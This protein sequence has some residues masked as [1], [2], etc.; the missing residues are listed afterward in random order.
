MKAEAEADAAR[1][2]T[3][4][5]FKEMYLDHIEGKVSAEARV[6]DRPDSADAEPAVSRGG[7]RTGGSKEEDDEARKTTKSKKD[8][9]SINSDAK[10][11]SAASTTGAAE[12]KAKYDLP[13]TCK[14]QMQKLNRIEKL[15]E[16]YVLVAHPF[17]QLE[18]EMLLFQNIVEDDKE[19]K[20]SNVD[21]ETQK[22][23]KDCIIYKDY[24]LRKRIATEP[25]APRITAY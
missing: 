9:E 10:R 24:S 7:A 19:N 20:D 11:G 3:F 14:L 15:D 16:D 5:E 12:N 6:K 2:R 13:N 22:L 18:G 8:Y 23:I 1:D 4:E 21:E 25:K 17:P